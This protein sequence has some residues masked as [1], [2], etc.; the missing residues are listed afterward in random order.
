MSPSHGSSMTTSPGPHCSRRSVSSWWL[1]TRLGIC[2][3]SDIHQWWNRSCT[4]QSR[5]GLG[6]LS[7]IVMMLW[8]FSTCT[9][10]TRQVTM[11]HLHRHLVVKLVMVVVPWFRSLCW[12]LEPFWPLGLDFYSFLVFR[13]ILFFFFY[14]SPKNKKITNKF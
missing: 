5:L 10:Q 1:C 2:L 6:R 3:G 11:V 14:A 8:G 4:L 13:Y 12:A 7:F 9:E